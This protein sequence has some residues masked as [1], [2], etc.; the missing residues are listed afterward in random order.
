MRILSRLLFAT[1]VLFASA[2]VLAEDPLATVEALQ[3]QR[4]GIPA[5]LDE[6]LRNK[7]G[8]LYDQAIKDRKQQGVLEQEI[9]QLKAQ[10]EQAPQRIEG[11]QLQL[12]QLQIPQPPQLNPQGTV[13]EVAVVLRKAETDLASLE[14]EE[15]GVR[16]QIN[17]LKQRVASSTEEIVSYREKLQQ[18]SSDLEL[19][20]VEGEEP[21]LVSA[22][23]SALLVRKSLREHQITHYQLQTDHQELLN[24]LWGSHSELLKQQIKNQQGLLEQLREQLQSKREALAQSNRQRAEEERVKAVGLPAPIRAIAEENVRLSE[25]AG[26]I[27][28]A[29]SEAANRLQQSRQKLNWLKSEREETERRVAFIGDSDAI[30]RVLLKRKR[31][32]PSL[33]NYRRDLLLRV[34]EIDRISNS[35]IDVEERRRDLQAGEQQLSQVMADSA[36]EIDGVLEGIEGYRAL[37]EG[38]L[39]SKAEQ[40]LNDQKEQLVQLSQLYSGY[41][42]RLTELDIAERQLV[43][44]SEKFSSYIDERLIWI[45]NLQPLS[46]QDLLALGESLRWLLDSDN[47]QQLFQD[48]LQAASSSPSRLIPLLVVLLLLVN[49]NGLQRN[50]LQITTAR[51]GVKE[52]NIGYTLSAL[53]YTTLL[54]APLPMLLLLLQWLLSGYSFA[55]PFSHALMSPLPVV[56]VTLAV[57]GFFQ[58][59]SRDDG[60]GMRH[61]NWPP[62]VCESVRSSLGVI[63]WTLPLLL[64]V[65]LLSPGLEQEEQLLSGFGRPALI[66]MMLLLIYLTLHH[67]YFSDLLQQGLVAQG[68]MWLAR[69]LRMGIVPLMLLIALTITL[70]SAL[71]YHHSALLLAGNLYATLLFLLLILLL[72]DVTRRFLQLSDRRLRYEELLKRREEMR[73]QRLRESEERGTEMPQE[74]EQ[75]SIDIQQLSG[76]AQRIFQTSFYLLVAVGLWMIW[77]QMIPALAVLESVTFPFTT[78]ELVDGIEKVR[79]INLL[80]VGAGLFLVLITVVLTQN[81]P[82]LIEIILLQRLPLETGSRYA[83]RTLAQYL[84]AAIGITA[85]FNAIGAEW[86]SIQW[87]VAALSVGLGFGLQE[88]V[89]NFVSGIILLFE[90]PIRV[91]DT[92]TVG[93]NNGVVV[94]IRIRATTIRTWDRQELVVPNKEFITSQVLNWTLGD[95][96]NRVVISVGVAY[97]SDVDRAHTLMLEAASELDSIMLDPAPTVSFEEFGD[98]ALILRIRCYLDAID[99]R[100]GVITEMH[101]R[102]NNKFNQ[103]GISMAFPQR[104]IHFDSDQPLNIRL[105]KQN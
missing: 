15:K 28:Q 91:G 1:A 103:A 33:E 61:F 37:I 50:L 55:A 71:G 14:L 13:D 94:R 86:S 65:V 30:G 60:V 89:A 99:N 45:A 42:S 26:V 77:E 68:R 8:E 56:A 16:D 62:M 38:N 69:L 4:E 22:R 44:E 27:T 5:E 64:F 32:L 54:V 96:V 75:E 84:I 82:G 102:I 23:R 49:R 3:Q 39:R 66:A 78:V 25:E 24:R 52:D 105:L 97:G 29:S 74:L 35:I 90:R 83:I 31:G 85:I 72:Q 12:E 67:L 57:I 93:N 104:D 20:V 18:I 87:L 59:A 100:L 53:A 41:I 36:I 21:L 2:M 58:Q 95:Q 47:W 76:E 88:I 17:R 79:A 48:L 73:Q 34:E 70:S 80:D 81:L 6:V 40:L 7:L 92:V 46:P 101:R 98:N 10:V 63:R 19:P 51:R 11:F 9:A 43:S